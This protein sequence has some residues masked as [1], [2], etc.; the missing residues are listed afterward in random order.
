MTSIENALMIK[1]AS[2]AF[3]ATRIS[4]INEIANICEVLGADVLQVIHGMGYDKRIGH[5]YLNPGAGFGGPCLEKDLKSLIKAAENA[6][7]EP[8]FL[9]SILAKNE[10][11]INQVMLKIRKVMGGILNGKQVGVLGLS[12]KPGTDNVRNSISLKLIY[13]LRDSG[14]QIKAYDPYAMKNAS[15]ALSDIELVENAYEVAKGAHLLLVLTGWEEFKEL[16][17]RRIRSEMIT[18]K[19]VDAVNILDPTRVKSLGF[20]YVGVG[21]C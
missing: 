14:A 10:H 11:Q 20:K 17:L 7:Y 16:D 1:Y 13:W 15:Q 3:L 21:R 19:I 18:P 9:K 8:L 12:F 2:N 4:F 5:I 6:A